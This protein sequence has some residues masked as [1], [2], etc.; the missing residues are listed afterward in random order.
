MP[1]PSKFRPI[2]RERTGSA[3]VL[4]LIMT[5]S[6]AGLAIS[7]IYLSS[8]AGLLSRYY[9]KERDY[10]YAAEA[11]LAMGKARLMAKD[12][13]LVLPEDTALK[14]VNAGTLTDATGATIPNIRVNVYGAFT[15]D[16]VGRFGNFVTLLASAYDSGGTRHVRRLDLAAESFSRFAMFTNQFSSGLYYG[17]GEFIRG[18]AHSN[19][20]W[21]STG[22]TGPRYF[23][24]VT[25]VTTV[26][27][28]ATYDLG[29]RA[30]DPVIPYPTVAKLAVLPTY[31]TAGG[32][33]FTPV[34]VTSGGKTSGTWLNFVPVNVNNDSIAGQPNIQEEE[35]LFR[36][37]DLTTGQ[38]TTRIRADMSGSPVALTNSVLQN[39]CGAG[40]WING[41]WQFFPVSTFRAVWV[42]SLIR[43]NATTTQG[44]ATKLFASSAALA[45]L[46]AGT[47]AAVAAILGQTNTGANPRC[48][49][50]GD[51]H[52]MLAE[53]FTN[54][55]GAYSAVAPTAADSVPFGVVVTVPSHAYGGDDTT[56]TPWARDCALITATQT[57]RCQAA[58]ADLGHWRPWTGTLI[59]APPTAVRQANERAYLW[60]MFKPYNLNAKGVIYSGGRIYMSG[61][62]RGN[63][64]VYAMGQVVFIDDLKYDIDPSSSAALC[65]NFLGVIAR[66]SVMLA[67]NAMNR[68]RTVAAG[69]NYLLSENQD[70]F[71]H[72]VTM[73]LNG[74]VGVENFAGTLA[75]TTSAGVSA[76]IKCPK[77]APN[78]ATSGGCVNQT[79]GVIEQ[80]ISATYTGSA[81]SGLRENRT[82][83]PCQLTNRKP[84][85]FPST[86]RYVDNKYYEIDP[87]NVDTWAQVKNFYARLRGRSA[88]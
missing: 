59:P 88:P 47:Q 54:S 64:T 34:A 84:P 49:P 77:T 14:M 22:T 82:V 21:Q 67:D 43:Q 9:D 24:T 66:D 20:R 61:V 37:F 36:L 65:R 80:T 23:D 6:L 79:G 33:N 29:F 7:A 69:I 55:A 41:R 75:T 68:P 86:G 58:P 25:A 31:A 19:Q 78:Y 53:R 51:P 39:Q 26:S 44:G 3:L 1:F 18:R 10:R 70:F 52:L 4:V 72:G 40:Y 27:G 13:G 45:P 35:G 48:Y 56:F 15:G 28:T 74:T 87:V 42:D 32:L 50:A 76:P 63:V 16:T 17:D 57:G 38:D 12:T 83:D 81:N 62:L 46:V 8:S 30:G 71:L 11:A 2:S 85:F 73:S 60:P 5:L